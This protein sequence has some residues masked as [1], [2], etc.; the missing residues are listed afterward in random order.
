MPS[1]TELNTKWRKSRFKGVHMGG[2]KTHFTG[3]TGVI[4]TLGADS[5]GDTVATFKQTGGRKLGETL[6]VTG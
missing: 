3:D 4:R 5:L 6:P 2:N 1:Y